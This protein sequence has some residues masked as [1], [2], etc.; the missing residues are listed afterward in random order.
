MVLSKKKSQMGANIVTAG[1]VLFNPDIN[2]LNEN[3]TA[4][5]PQ[6]NL[7][8]LVDNH[9]DNLPAI[10]ELI[11]SMHNVHLIQNSQNKGI[12]YALNQILQYSDSISAEWVLTLD[13]DSVVPT[14]LI[15]EYMKFMDYPHVGLLTCIIED[16][17]IGVLGDA[18]NNK[19]TITELG[20]CITSASLINI[21]IAM[22]IGGF[23]EMLFIDSVDH[24]FCIRLRLEGYSILRVNSARLL[25][26]VGHSR[27]V[28]LCGQKNIIYN[29]SPFRHYYI[30]RNKI[31]LGRKFNQR[32][33]YTRKAVKHMLLV[34]IYETSKLKKIAS[35]IK[36]LYDGMKIKISEYGV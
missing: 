36:G 34:A 3:L 8:I 35:M 5:V 13:Q 18:I 26:E 15:S 31:I 4:I 17:N 12:A 1:I 10:R 30:V 16:R 2:R 14:N 32:F 33:F 7:V 9:S 27:I 25:H 19:D 21:K 29:H 20:E 23:D 6:V 22:I 24:D 11:S 28:N